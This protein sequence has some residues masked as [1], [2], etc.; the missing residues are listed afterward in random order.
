MMTTLKANDIVRHIKS[1]K[2][3]RVVYESHN[4]GRFCVVGQRDHKDFGPI[5]VMDAHKLQPQESDFNV[6]E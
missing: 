1:G 3:Y 4:P 5:R 2:L 6:N